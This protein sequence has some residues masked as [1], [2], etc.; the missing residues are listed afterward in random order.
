MWGGRA[1]GSVGTPAQSS[2][3][4]AAHLAFGMRATLRAPWGGAVG[5]PISRSRCGTALPFQVGAVTKGFQDAITLAH[6]A[7]HGELVK[8]I[9][10]HPK[11]VDFKRHGRRGYA[12]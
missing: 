9:R 10:D 5:A 3:V 2:A 12:A 8:L 6:T 1:Y 11:V 7:G 4:R